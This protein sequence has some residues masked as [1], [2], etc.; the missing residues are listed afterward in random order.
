MMQGVRDAATDRR[1]LVKRNGMLGEVL[2]Q[3][4]SLD[5]F[6]SDVRP[7][8]FHPGIVDLHDSRMLEPSCRASLAQQRLDF[9]AIQAP[10]PGNLQ[11]DLAFQNRIVS[12]IDRSKSAAA[13]LFDQLESTDPVIN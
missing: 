6:A 4:R 12:P 1:R 13:N 3:R 5:E 9:A 2:P 7:R 10:L 11:G 8:A